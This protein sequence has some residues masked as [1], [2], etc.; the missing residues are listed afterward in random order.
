MRAV[1]DDAKTIKLMVQSGVGLA[2]LPRSC[3]AAES[4][5]ETIGVVEVRPK[6]EL[7][8]TLARLA[9]GDAS[10][11]RYFQLLRSGLSG[12]RA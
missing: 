7:R 4:A 8:M 10:G 9:R 2:L 6:I 11:D 1:S 5:N 12:L 3:V